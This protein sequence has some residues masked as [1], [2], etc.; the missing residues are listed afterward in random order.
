MQGREDN[1]PIFVTEGGFP[2]LLACGK[3]TAAC[4]QSDR[5]A[6]GGDEVAAEEGQVCSA[7][8]IVRITSSFHGLCRSVAYRACAKKDL[9]CPPL[10]AESALSSRVYTRLAPPPPLLAQPLKSFEL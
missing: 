3:A 8:A 1:W 2:A 9:V 10:P 4:A 6:A 7:A 5:R